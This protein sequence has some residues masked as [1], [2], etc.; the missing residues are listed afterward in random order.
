M[1]TKFRRFI[2]N[3]TRLLQEIESFLEENKIEGETVWLSQA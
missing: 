3:K 2:G 1:G